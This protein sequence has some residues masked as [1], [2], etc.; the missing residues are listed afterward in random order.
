MS[1]ELKDA[2]SLDKPQFIGF[3]YERFKH[4]LEPTIHRPKDQAEREIIEETICYNHDDI[5]TL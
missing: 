4:Y 2:F 3:V 5:Q 1:Q